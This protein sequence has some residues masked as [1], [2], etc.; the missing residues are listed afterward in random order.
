MYHNGIGVSKD[1]IIAE[2]WYIKAAKG[3]DVRAR[4]VLSSP[5]FIFKTF[6]TKI[7]N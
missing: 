4:K 2:R 3:G 1:Y 7:F 6:I 5:K